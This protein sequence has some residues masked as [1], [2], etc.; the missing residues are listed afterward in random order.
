VAGF[1]CDGCE[2]WN[3]TRDFVDQKNSDYQLLKED[4]V[5]VVISSYCSPLFWS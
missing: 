2:P 1:C 4:C 5:E 3:Y